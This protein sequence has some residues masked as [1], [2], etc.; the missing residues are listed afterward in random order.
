[1][2]EARGIN[3]GK[4]ATL[5]G[6][7]MEDEMFIHNAAK[8]VID[9]L[10]CMGRR[11]HCSPTDCPRITGTSWTFPSC[12][13]YGVACRAPESLGEG[14]W[15]K[16]LKTILGAAHVH[17]YSMPGARDDVAVRRPSGSLVAVEVQ[18]SPIDR[19]TML[20]RHAARRATGMPARFGGWSLSI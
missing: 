17:E 13:R 1:M 2:F 9:R 12:A 20:N 19:E 6:S 7:T 18:N 4:I 8:E 16:A 5:L 10:T 11:L 15:H 14:K 3:S